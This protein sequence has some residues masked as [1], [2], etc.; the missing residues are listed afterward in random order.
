MIG[1]NIGSKKTAEEYAILKSNFEDLFINEIK[2]N[3][4]ETNVIVQEERSINANVATSAIGR[5]I[6]CF[7]MIVF[8]RLKCMFVVGPL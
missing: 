3:N 5:K 8:L 6:Y 1:I 4:E 7:I 2:E